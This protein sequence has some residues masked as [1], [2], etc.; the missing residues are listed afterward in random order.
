M[1]KNISRLIKIVIFIF[2]IAI[3]DKV[4]GF[5]LNKLYFSQTYGQNHSLNY[6]LSECKAD[7]LIF[8]NSRAQH[9]YDSRIISKALKMSCYNAGQDGGHSIILPYAQIKIMTERHSPKILILEFSPDGILH[10]TGDYDRLHILLP[11][12]EE[13]PEIRPLVLLES[14]YESIKL[15]S[16]IYPFNSNLINIIRF[17]TDYHAVRQQ[18]FEGYVPLKKVMS[19][20]IL[21]QEPEILN[22][23]VIATESVVD[24]NKVNALEH[25]IS[26]CKEK[27][28]SL[29]II[30]SPIFH[31]VNE[32]QSPPLPSA[33]LSLEIIHRNNVNYLDFSHDSTFSGHFELFKDRE[34]LNVEGAKVFSNMLID[35]IEKTLSLST[36][37]RF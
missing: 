14:P 18:D 32:K 30:N 26:L 8:G 24:S 31:T 23:S 35:S 7:V 4:L 19:I 10:Y 22:Q 15:T 21:K 16:T 9:H 37:R 36:L 12:C 27:N 3:T 29:F 17:N 20:N 33:K 34:H 28:I 11:Y 2:I 5:I 6:V 25:I 1:N 13:Y